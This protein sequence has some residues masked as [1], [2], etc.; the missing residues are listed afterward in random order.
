DAFTP[1]GQVAEICREGRDLAN[2]RGI[3]FFVEIHRNNFTENL[4]QIKELIALVPDMRFTA[5]LCHLV[6]CGE[7]YGWKEERAVDRLLRVLERTSHIH[8]RI[9][10]GE[11]VQVD[12]GDGSGD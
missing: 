2:E 6:V 3:P 8:G 5:D 4:P 12:V 10:N 11:A 1:V 7:F 9:S